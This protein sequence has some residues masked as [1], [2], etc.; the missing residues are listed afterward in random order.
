MHGVDLS[1]LQDRFD[2]NGALEGFATLRGQWHAGVLQVAEQGPPQWPASTTQ[3]WVE[4]P[5]PVPAGGWPHGGESENLELPV[6]LINDPATVHLLLVRPSATQVVL[7]VV[8]SDPQATFA[9]WSRVFPNR[10]CVVEARWPRG[11]VER[12]TRQAQ[13]R[14]AEFQAYQAGSGTGVGY[15]PV[16][17]LDVVLVVV[18]LVTWAARVPDGLLQ[19]N[20][21]LHPR[22]QS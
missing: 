21:W 1:R 19:V 6:A 2:K 9:T 3:D 15:Q 13:S 7:T 22:R 17:T 18:P 16:I 14:M 12:L 4:P 8:S 10:L 11:Q 20:A 5:C